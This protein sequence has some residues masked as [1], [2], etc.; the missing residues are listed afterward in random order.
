LSLLS[1]NIDD[2][3]KL[4]DF[5]ISCYISKFSNGEKNEMKQVYLLGKIPPIDLLKAQI[6]QAIIVSKRQMTENINTTKI[7]VNSVDKLFESLVDISIMFSDN[8]GLIKIIKTIIQSGEETKALIFKLYEEINKQPATTIGIKYVNRCALCGTETSQDYC[9]KCDDIIDTVDE[10]SRR[11]L[12][13]MNQPLFDMLQK[14]H[15]T[16]KY[17]GLF[18][19][20]NDYATVERLEKF[21]F[22]EINRNIHP[23]IIKITSKGRRLLDAWNKSKG[24]SKT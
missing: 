2:A 23:K 5:G 22:I 15:D 12:S 11:F 20:S 14:I 1:L 18:N 24:T 4:K 16:L 3:K 7:F 13:K 6:P 19:D 21:N 8:V 17:D 9:G 10:D